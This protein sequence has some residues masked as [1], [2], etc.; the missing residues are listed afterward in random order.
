MHTES[1]PH[2][3]CVPLRVAYDAQA[4]VSGDGGTGKGAQLRN[5]I[6]SRCAHFQGYAPSADKKEFTGIVR[7]GAGRYLIWQ[8]ASLPRMLKPWK[9]DVF[10]AP[11]NT[12]P[13]WLP[14]GTQLVLVLHDLILLQNFR[15][16]SAR[17]RIINSYRRRL[18]PFSVARSRHVLT[19]S[20]YS[21][22]A[23]LQSFPDTRVT[24]IPC[25]I[26]ETWFTPP[27]ASLQ[28][29]NYILL[30]TGTPPHKN[31]ARALCAYASYVK[32]SG[33]GATNLRVVGLALAGEEF[34]S[35]VR[36]AG[37]GD[38]V[39]FEPFV[40]SLTLQQLYRQ[41]RAV[42]VPSLMEGFGIPVLEAMA[43]GTPVLASRS[44]SL[45]E[46]GGNAIGCFDPLDEES[47]AAAIYDLLANPELCLQRSRKG[48]ERAARF[49]PSVIRAQV[50]EFWLQIALEL[51]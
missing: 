23:I 45:A 15:A 24:V 46:V 3:P 41:A 27:D 19:V 43:S 25:T 48:Y 1:G 31:A 8:Q 33:A 37:I 14:S 26:P 18:I 47:M 29:G 2:S 20:E 22:I 21:R 5:L 34:H 39:T 35:I 42:I 50:D 7:G 28:R 6:N 51:H 30:A 40:S 32:R 17:M 11:Y 16:S 36:D 13:L 9:P 44:T 4:L 38:K 49:H 10:L 12:A